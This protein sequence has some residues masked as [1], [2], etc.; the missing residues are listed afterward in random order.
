VNLQ[1]WLLPYAE[2][3]MHY[4]P[5]RR[6]TSSWRSYSEQWMLYRRYLNGQSKYPAAPPGR[7][8]HNYGRAWDVDDAN[9]EQLAYMGAVWESWG[10]RW[11]GRYGDPIHFEA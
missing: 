9:L 8:M 11:G 7:S 4:F 2:W 5:E 1:P 3:L 10:G 6:V